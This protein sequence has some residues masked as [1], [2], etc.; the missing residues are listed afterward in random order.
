MFLKQPFKNQLTLVH[1]L[2]LSMALQFAIALGIVMIALWGMNQLSHSFKQLDEQAL[3]VAELAA[4]IDRA[5]LQLDRQLRNTISSQNPETFAEQRALF[6]SE[7]N[8]LVTALSVFTHFSQGL[9]LLD[10]DQT[11]IAESVAKLDQDMQ[12]LLTRVEQRLEVQNEVV[13]SQGLVLYA[14]GSARDEMSR[15]VPILFADIAESKMA[16]D[17]FIADAA[18]L[19]NAQL[20]L[21]TT[22]DPN[23]A[24]TQ[25]KQMQSYI[26]RLRFNY[27]ILL[28]DNPEL[29]DYP[30]VSMAIDILEGAVI[31]AGLFGLQ[32]KQVQLN[33]AIQQDIS[34]LSEPLDTLQLHLEKLLAEGVTIIENATQNTQLTMLHSQRL[35]LA[36]SA[37][38]IMVFVGLCIVIVRL[39]RSRVKQIGEAIHKLS[40]GDFTHSCPVSSP[41]EFRQLASWLNQ[42]SEH[43]RSNIA[44]L[45]ARGIEL[46]QAAEASANI[47]HSQQQQ[48]VEQENRIALIASSVVQMDT[49]MGDIANA[50]ND[51]E[52]DSQ[53]SAE[54]A[55]QG[56]QTLESTSTHLQGLADK[57]QRNS[58]RMSELDQQ[59]DQVGEVVQVINSIAERTNLL[60]LN[61]A[62]E[63]AR[64]GQHGR[65]FA[66][67]ADEVRKLAG[68]TREQTD[69]ISEMI[70]T[71][72][73]ATNKARE[74]MASCQNEMQSTQQLSEHLSIAMNDIEQAVATVRQQTVNISRS[75]AEQNQASH[76]VNQAV[77]DLVKQS[78]LRQ[79]QIDELSVQ[80]DQVAAIA[81]EQGQSLAAFK[82]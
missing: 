22:Q 69:S 32:A 56:K 67:V 7:L 39:V 79:S 12:S 53:L 52:Q 55:E 35:L 58:Q 44:Q 6:D 50:G 34:S 15:L 68:Q 65:G 8:T 1:Q 30:S 70:N 16:Y 2:A 18:S 43:N 71:L 61:A 78:Q 26:S 76:H 3:P 33:F 19:M 49:T 72:H 63:A 4:Q 27:N 24:Q 31:E 75:T 46:K 23:N 51:A 54:L 73:N 36:L 59:V 13:S 45:R 77:D 64:A 82:V 9:D 11:R 40:Q 60:A 62:I 38:G 20:Q 66:V 80:S 41:R 17:A 42:A 48:L 29:A 74:S 47:A 14:M 10:D 57:M 81:N 5:A 21:V 28:K 25:L 37:V